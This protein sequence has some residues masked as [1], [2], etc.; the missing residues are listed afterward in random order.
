MQDT[1]EKILW[2]DTETTGLSATGYVPRICQIAWI[3]VE[4]KCP[5]AQ[6]C[7][8]LKLPS[9]VKIQPGAAQVHGITRETL[10]AHGVRPD[11]ALA[12]FCQHLR[13][14]KWL[15][16]HNVKFDRERL[17]DEL[18]LIEGYH[19]TTILERI[20]KLPSV[21]TMDL[22]RDICQLPQTAEMIAEGREGFKPPR[23][24]EAYAKV[25]GKELGNAHDAL[26]DV[27]A[28]YEIYSCLRE[29]AAGASMR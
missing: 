6:A 5:V 7:T 9:G 16:G 24:S 13:G 20:Q 18:A 17:M 12:L 8:Y 15:G 11:V 29:G 21:C 27:L 1:D 3:V 23:L 26:V 22:T 28:S 4:D 10:D 14:C 25:C 19:S 2:F